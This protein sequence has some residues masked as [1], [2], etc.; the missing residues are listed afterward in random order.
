MIIY[1]DSSLKEACIHDGEGY[2]LWSYDEP[3]TNNVGEYK[4][5]LG[6]IN[7]AQKWGVKDLEVRTDSELVVC[8]VNGVYNCTKK[9]L[10]VLRN[11]VRAESK[12]FNNFKISWVSREDNPAGKILEGRK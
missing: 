10:R 6:A 3:V 1:C 8:Q 11:K 4:A 2:G 9:H 12:K 7:L 5:V